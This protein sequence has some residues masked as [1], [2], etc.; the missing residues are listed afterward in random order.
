[1]VAIR[2][3][4]A[5]G[6]QFS[7]GAGSA[8]LP[9]TEGVFLHHSGGR[10]ENGPQAVRDLEVVGQN[11]FGA[12][13][14]YTFAVSPDGTIWEGHSIDREGS[15]TKR[16]NQR[17]RAIVLMGNFVTATPTAQQRE[18][19]AQLLAHG[20]R[21]GWWSS[22]RLRGHREVRATECPGDAGQATIPGIVARAKAL[23]AGGAP[24]EPDGPPT[25]QILGLGDTG[26][27]VRFLQALL[28]IITPKAK[29]GDRQP[30]ALSG[31]YDARTAA[32]VTEFQRWANGML[33]LAGAE[34][35]F[36][37]EDGVAGPETLASIAF[38]V[39]GFMDDDD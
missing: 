16:H 26:E 39:P 31:T 12:G 33:K 29:L 14:S 34:D 37:D 4:S 24:I 35:G 13:I 15:H 36:L 5:W 28:N 27:E 1:M 8:P 11:E 32:R 23:L 3:R 38:W 25:P 9:A 2:P 6:P 7:N 22:T 30:L 18:S 20:V 17:G 21:Q 19:A 10:A